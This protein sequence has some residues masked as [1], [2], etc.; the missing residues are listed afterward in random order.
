VEQILEKKPK[1]MV[2]IFD[3]TLEERWCLIGFS[4]VPVMQA[5][6]KLMIRATTLTV[7]WN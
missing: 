4:V 1:E 2:T 5:E 6:T 3:Q 7:S